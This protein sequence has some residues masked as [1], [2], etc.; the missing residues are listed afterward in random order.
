MYIY[1]YIH[2]YI[3][4]FMGD[5]LD[6]RRRIHGSR[7]RSARGFERLEGTVFRASNYYL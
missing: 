2:T 3:C 1:I 4:L 6:A 5:D 7:A